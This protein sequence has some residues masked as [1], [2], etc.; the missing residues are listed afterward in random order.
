ML[1]VGLTGGIGSG[2]STVSQMFKENN[3]KVIDCDII[4]RE[5]FVLYPEILNKIKNTFGERYFDNFG[6]LKRQELGNYI[7]K[8]AALKKK[9]EDIT[10]AYITKEVIKRLEQY[11]NGKEK[12]CV[13]DAPTLIEVG[14]HKIM[15]FNILVWVDKT[16]QVARVK[17]RDF[18]NEEQI[19]NRI[20]SQMPLDSKKKYAD[21][22]IDNSKDLKYTKDQFLKILIK[23]M[24]LRGNDEA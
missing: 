15:D 14:M 17:N 24:D 9:L 5:I 7:F 21:Y 20:E 8:D 10:L 3:I 1:K 22:I 11:K 2:K 18:F 13:V 19:M 12:I 16:T 6:N 23:L 4:S